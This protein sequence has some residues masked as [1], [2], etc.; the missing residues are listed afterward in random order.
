MVQGLV[1]SKQCA[2]A[3]VWFC[4]R[5]WLGMFWLLLVLEYNLCGFIFEPGI[6]SCI[7]SVYVYV[8]DP[9]SLSPQMKQSR[10]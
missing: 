1:F 3:G 9:P 8:S 2:A 6:H 5:T 7:I 4:H 10:F